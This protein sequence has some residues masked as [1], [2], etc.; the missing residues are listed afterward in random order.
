MKNSKKNH[1][2]SMF[3]FSYYQIVNVFDLPKRHSF[4]VFEKLYQVVRTGKMSRCNIADRNISEREVVFAIFIAEK[5]F[6][7]FLE[8]C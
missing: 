3:Y 2:S 7:S 5:K 1:C 6:L 8:N 4:V